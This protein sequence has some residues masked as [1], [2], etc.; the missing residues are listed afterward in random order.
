MKKEVSIKIFVAFIMILSLLY[1]AVFAVLFIMDDYNDAVKYENKMNIIL[2]YCY[3]YEKISNHMREI[4]MIVYPD[5]F[6]RRLGY[7]RNQYT[8]QESINSN[9]KDGLKVSLVNG[10]DL[11]VQKVIDIVILDQ[12]MSEVANNILRT[13]NINIDGFESEID[14]ISQLLSEQKIVYNPQNSFHDIQR[15][16][17]GEYSDQ[18]LYAIDVITKKSGKYLGFDSFSVLNNNNWKFIQISMNLAFLVFVLLI[19]NYSY[20]KRGFKLRLFFSINASSYLISVII[21]LSLIVSVFIFVSNSVSLLSL[22][23]YK[24]LS[25]GLAGEVKAIYYLLFLW[26]AI[27]QSLYNVLML[28]VLQ[29]TYFEF[30][31]ASSQSNEFEAEIERLKA[32]EIE[33]SKLDESIQALQK[34]HERKTSGCLLSTLFSFMRK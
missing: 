12:Q 14:T 4:E 10:E 11:I 8:L 15:I 16:L 6:R 23:K 1:V 32:C 28:V 24:E 22:S 20:Y 3:K 18:F 27:S 7:I 19:I 26:E 31:I 21:L 13:L 33:I 9:A 2:D 17:H 34:N 29:I 5:D 25:G 30:V